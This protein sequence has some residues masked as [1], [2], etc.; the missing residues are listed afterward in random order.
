MLP[1]PKKTTSGLAGL[2]RSAHP[3]KLCI[4]H[5]RRALRAGQHFVR[6]FVVFEALLHWVPVEF[7]FCLHS[8]MVQ[9][10]RRAGPVADFRRRSRRVSALNAFQPVTV[11][12]A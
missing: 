2:A 7:A 8:D 12:I 1:N 11:L 6:C 3:T 4:Q 10:T 5:V 9:K